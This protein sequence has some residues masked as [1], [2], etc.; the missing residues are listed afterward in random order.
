MT[1][2]MNQTF[3]ALCITLAKYIS[4]GLESWE[5]VGL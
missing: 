2:S 1:M 3:V 4:V 5:A